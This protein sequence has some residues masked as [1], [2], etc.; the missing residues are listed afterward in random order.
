MSKENTWLFS[1]CSNDNEHIEKLFTGDKL[2]LN[3]EHYIL[4]RG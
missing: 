2:P 4:L 3:S 1:K